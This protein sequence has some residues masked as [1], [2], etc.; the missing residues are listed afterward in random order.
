MTNL[1]IQGSTYII[2]SPTQNVGTI[3]CACDS[4]FKVGNLGTER[5]G[6]VFPSWTFIWYL[7]FNIETL[8]PLFR[9]TS[10]LWHT[11]QST[12]RCASTGNSLGPWWNWAKWK[13]KSIISSSEVYNSKQ[14]IPGATWCTKCSLLAMGFIFKCHSSFRRWFAQ[15]CAIM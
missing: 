13:L 10:G 8:L 14:M 15:K 9:Q 6:N 5:A 11:Y 2:F 4:S 7:G 1:K 3:K 12:F